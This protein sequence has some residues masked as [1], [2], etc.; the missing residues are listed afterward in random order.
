MSKLLIPL[1]QHYT[2]RQKYAFYKIKTDFMI[3]YGLLNPQFLENLGADA[4]RVT[5]SKTPPKQLNNA[6][7]KDLLI[8]KQ[9]SINK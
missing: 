3:K 6:L 8:R 4:K 7:F 2:K 1:I 5:A 9:L